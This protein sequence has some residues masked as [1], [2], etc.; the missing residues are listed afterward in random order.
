M[1]EGAHTC[2]DGA[3]A[4][5]V[6]YETPEQFIEGIRRWRLV[7]VTAAEEKQIPLFLPLL[8][9]PSFWVPTFLIGIF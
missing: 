9:F 1:V 7:S 5:G 6:V 2:E 8:S 4:N 3:D